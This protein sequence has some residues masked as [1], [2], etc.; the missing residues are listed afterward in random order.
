MNDAPIAFDPFADNSLESF[1]RELVKREVKTAQ[2]CIPAIVTQVISRE[3]VMVRPAINQYN[4]KWETVEWGEIKL[5]VHA[6]G[7]NG[8]FMSFKP[9]VDSTGWI[10]AGDLDPALFLQKKGVQNQNT[11]DRHKYQFGFFV[12]DFITNYAWQVPEEYETDFVI[13]AANTTSGTDNT[14]GVRLSINRNG[15]IEI[16]A[17]TELKISGK[18]ITINSDDNTKVIIDGVNFKEH[19]HK[20]GSLKVPTTSAE[21]SPSTITGNTGAVND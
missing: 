6:Y 3:L 20:V 12:P 4:A 10:I 21:G 7:S 2:F 15:E 8:V 13:Y 17:K 9:A 19:T 14:R 18:N 5:P 1:I 16:N 11:L